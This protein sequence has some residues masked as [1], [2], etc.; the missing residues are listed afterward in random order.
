MLITLGKI[1]TKT[2]IQL[3]QMFPLFENIAAEIWVWNQSLTISSVG[4]VY[5]LMPCLTFVLNVLD[6]VIS[7]RMRFPTQFVE[8]WWCHY[9]FS[10]QYFGVYGHEVWSGF[11][12]MTIKKIL[13]RVWKWAGSMEAFQMDV[14][15]SFSYIA[16]MQPDTAHQPPERLQSS[17]SDLSLVCI[18]VIEVS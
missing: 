5:P 12:L 18:V 3:T 8:L 1:A 9:P 16:G 2:W 15:I 11:F 17:T 4:T 6:L 7:N 14:I 13:V 10:S